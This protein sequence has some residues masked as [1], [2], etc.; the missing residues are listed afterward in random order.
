MTPQLCRPRCFNVMFLLLV[1]DGFEHHAGVREER[2]WR[3]WLDEDLLA[4][5]V[6][7]SKATS[8]PAKSCGCGH[9]SL[10]Y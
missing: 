5:S 7:A 2:V 1:A 9:S 4:I 3:V 10:K 6:E 8:T